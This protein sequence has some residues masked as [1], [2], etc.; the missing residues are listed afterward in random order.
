MLCLLSI[1]KSELSDFE[2]DVSTLKKQEDFLDLTGEKKTTCEH[3]QYRV[4]VM[5]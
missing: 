1:N 2:F 3:S 4:S 5:L